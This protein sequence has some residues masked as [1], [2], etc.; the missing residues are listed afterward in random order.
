MEIV[1]QII[2][3]VVIEG[4]YALA[5]SD[6]TPKLLRVFILSSLTL[7]MFALF[8]LSYLLRSNPLLM[9]TLIIV[10]FFFALFLTGIFIT[11][12]KNINKYQD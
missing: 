6:K 10:G 11:H 9:W 3:E 8:Y 5:A 12:I 4:T 1:F 2:F 7:S